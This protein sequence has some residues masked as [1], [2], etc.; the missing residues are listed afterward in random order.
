MGEWLYIALPLK[1]FS[2]L[3]SIEIESYLKSVFEPLFGGDLGV[4]YALHL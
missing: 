3:H 2:R 4:T 1:I